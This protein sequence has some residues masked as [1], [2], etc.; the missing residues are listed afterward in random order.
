MTRVVLLKNHLGAGGGLEKYT[1]RLAVEFANAGC[2]TTL[3]TSHSKKTQI[4]SLPSVRCISL[5]MK[6]AINFMNLV[7]FDKKC[8]QWLKENPSDIIFGLDRNRSQTHYRAGNGVH[9]AYINQRRLCESWIKN[10]SFSIN[11]IHPLTINYEKAAFENPDL[12]LLFTNS[13][14]VKEQILSYYNLSP[15]KIQVVHNGVEWD[16]WQQPFDKWQ[17]EKPSIQ[18]RLGLDPHAFHLLFIGH[19][20]RR[21]GLQQLLQSLALLKNNNVQLSII[22]KDK[23]IPYFQALTKQLGLSKH[24]FFFGP[25]SQ[26]LPFYQMADCLIIP[27]LYDPFANVTV[28]ALAMGLFVISSKYNGGHEILTKNTG[29]IIEDLFSPE[30]ITRAIQHALNKPKTPSSSQLIRSSVQHLNFS[31]QLNTIIQATLHAS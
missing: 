3:L 23:E 24:V 4:P 25:Q 12:K 5:G 22:G 7:N 13:H 27:S 29:A 28:E 1:K 16:E 2:E 19:G 17:Q 11:P 31:N 10:A 20:Y 18:Q 15:G 9:A 6:K 26:I 30:S 14:F 21:K 8:R